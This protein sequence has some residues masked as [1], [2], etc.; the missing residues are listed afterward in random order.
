MIER[1]LGRFFPSQWNPMLNLGALG[2][3][4]YWIITVSGIYVYIFFDTGVNNAYASIEY[5]THE[6]W[7]LAGIMRSLHRYASDLLIIVMMIHLLR[8][9]ARDRYRGAHWFSWVTGVPVMVMMF[10]AGISGYWL[11]WD[12]LAQ[13]VAIVSTEW[14]DLLPIFGEPIARNFLSPDALESRFFT[15]MIFIHIAIPL[16]ALA[17]LWV[18]LQRVSKPVI[19]PPRGL[20]ISV[21]G[22]LMALSLFYPA[23]SQPPADLAMVPANVGLDW[24]YLPL[25]PLLETLPGSVTWGMGTCFLIIL[26]AMP[27]L[28]PLK[29]AQPAVVDLDNCNGCERCFSDCPYDAIDMVARSDGRAFE[30]E[31]L[32]NLNKCVACGLCAGA[33]PTSIPFRKMSKLSPGI[34][35]PDNTIVSLRDQVELVAR[36][37]VGPRRIMV[38][39]CGH[40]PDLSGVSSD[41]VGVVALVCIGQLPPAFIDYVLSRDL[42]DGV[43][44]TGCLEN[45]CDSR[46]G[47]DWTNA[48]LAGQRDP[49]LRGRVERAR[50]E[51]F[52]AGST[53][54][55]Q[56]SAAL[57]KFADS[58][59]ATALI[60]KARSE[61]SKVT[62]EGKPDA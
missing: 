42:A 47:I 34:D 44:L 36:G 8:E 53:G 39:N 19:N 18:H 52:W 17:I 16:I 29:R 12:K 32:V 61:Q 13:Y 38:F 56:F 33:C 50:V 37:L 35:L 54:K 3:F 22:L 48:R 23:Y 25:Y 57:N 45:S 55:T 40:G 10:V 31:P 51:T 24:F 41:N 1:F 30:R 62:S 11:V 21:F 14:L 2:F 43:M 46:K 7:Y 58:L 15:L 28:P 6:Q 60:Q 5:M 26:V 9:F 27:W 59:D 49:H 4:F 20:A